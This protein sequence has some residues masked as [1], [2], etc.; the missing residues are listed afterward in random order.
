MPLLQLEHI[1]TKMENLITLI[2]QKPITMN[3]ISLG[4]I[5]KGRGA[6]I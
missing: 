3:Q 6:I 2:N 1:L 5:V 4:Q